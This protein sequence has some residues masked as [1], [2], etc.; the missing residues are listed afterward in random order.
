MCM[1]L[2]AP[3]KPAW[4][5][6]PDADCPMSSRQYATYL[7]DLPD[8]YPICGQEHV[9]VCCESVT[10]VHGEL[11]LHMYPDAAAYARAT[12]IED[13]LDAL[14]DIESVNDMI[15]NGPALIGDTC[16]VSECPDHSAALW[17]AGRAL[18][19]VADKYPG[20]DIESHLPEIW[21]RHMH[22]GTSRTWDGR[23]C[24]NIAHTAT[25]P[26]HLVSLAREL[27]KGPRCTPTR[28]VSE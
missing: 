22:C 12:F 3:G 27:A 11:R 15:I 28:I 10:L 23:D 18:K 5:C 25:P 8:A 9:H 13:V 24:N 17:R 21:L 4:M 16:A 6:A 1:F 19:A 20:V 26:V 2:V 7:V 14:K